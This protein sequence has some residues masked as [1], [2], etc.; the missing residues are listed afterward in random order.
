MKQ[1][2]KGIAFIH[3]RDIAHRDIKPVNIMVKS[4]PNSSVVLKLG[5]FGL[6]KIF[7]INPITSV[8]D[9]P[10]GTPSFQAPELWA[11]PTRYHR[12]ADIYAA[13]L[14][15]TAMIQVVGDGNLIPKA[16]GSLYLS[17]TQLHIGQ[18]AY[19]RQLNHEGAFNV[20]ED[21][22]NDTEMIKKVKLLIRKMTYVTPQ[23]RPVAPEVVDALADF[24]GTESYHFNVHGVTSEEI[25]YRR[26]DREA[27]YIHDFRVDLFNEIGRGAFGTVY[28]GYD[29]NNIVFAMKR[30]LPRQYSS[31]EAVKY[32][33]M[34]QRGIIH[35]HLVTVYDVKNFGGAIW[36]AMEYCD[37]GDLQ[38]FFHNY[39]EI[40]KEPSVK[41]KLM[42]Q[43]IS[44]VSFLHKS[45]IV[46]RDLKPSNILIKRTPGEHAVAKLGDVSLSK[47]LDPDSLTSAMSS[48][49]GTLRF[50]APEFW[51]IQ[52][53]GRIKYHR[54]VDVYAAGLTFTAMLQAKQGTSFVP[55]VEG[56]LEPS[57]SRMP[58]GLVAFNRKVQGESDLQIFESNSQD[59]SM[60]KQVKSIIQSMMEISPL[61]RL[62][63]SAVED[64][65][66]GILDQ[67]SILPMHSNAPLELTI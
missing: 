37:L 40:V 23:E 51:E 48:N 32:H 64:M 2:A 25:L 50:K 42:N 67:V 34:T 27:V 28:K 41:V 53:S 24:V 39:D 35:Q 55:S 21:A 13:G 49:I 22:V 52:P 65:L 44:G 26:D 1:I 19:L 29:S 54:N 5:D 31:N 45:N 30:L 10:L 62:P 47:F 56:S 63:V 17:E 12:S 14:T 3:G 59:T 66:L 11:V 8:M 36:I 46:H 60:E 18:A 6:S 38:S 61:D 15:F 4:L 7:Q 57:E 43:I 33:F 58:L 9:T 20:V 16:E